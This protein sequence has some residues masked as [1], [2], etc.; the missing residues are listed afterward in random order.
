MSE[1]NNLCK[2]SEGWIGRPVDC[3]PQSW[4]CVQCGMKMT[5]GEL[6]LL[7]E[8]RSLAAKMEVKHCA[9]GVPLA[10]CIFPSCGGSRWPVAT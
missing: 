3:V 5:P 9:C 6:L 1:A 4:E 10:D 8:I 7:N 2:H